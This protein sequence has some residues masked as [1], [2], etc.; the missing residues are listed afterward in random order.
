MGYRASKRL[1]CQAR[2][3]G[4]YSDGVAS[5]RIMVIADKSVLF[6][7]VEAAE[8]RRS[9]AEGHYVQEVAIPTPWVRAHRSHKACKAPTQSCELTR[10]EPADKSPCF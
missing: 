4:G 5:V 10:N 9:G 1:R 6:I 8:G 7:E 2:C 3:K